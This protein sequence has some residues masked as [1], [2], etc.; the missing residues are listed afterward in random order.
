M[1]INGV[2]S[3]WTAA[4]RR[5]GWEHGLEAAAGLA[6]AVALVS[7]LTG[8]GVR[9]GSVALP[10][11]EAWRPAL[12]GLVILAGR[13]VLSRRR[14]HTAAAAR[15]A[16]SRFDGL[17]VLACSCGIAASVLLWSHY[18]IRF[19]GGSDSYGYV[20]AAHALAEGH[21]IE[22]QPIAGWLTFANPIRAITPLGSAP[23]PSGNAIVPGYP[24]GLSVV[25]ALFILVAGPGAEFYVPLV[26][27]IGALVLCY[28]LTSRWADWRVAAIATL[29]IAC[30]PLIANMVIQPMSD[31]PALFWYLLAL[32]IAL[33]APR[34]LTVAGL[35]MGLAIWTR[36]TMLFVLP[37]V[38]WI[39][40]RTRD[41]WMRF[42]AGLVPVGAAVAGFQ[43]YMYG[44]PLKTGYG[45]VPGLFRASMALQN[46]PAY[47][48][49]LA[50]I[51]SPLVFVAFAIGVWRGP[52]RLLVA[53]LAGFA[54]GFLPY[55]FKAPFF[56]DYGLLRYV[57]QVLV[58][59]L[60]V[61][62][63]G[64]AELCRR[65]LSPRLATVALV[66]MTMA[67]ASYSY[68]VADR[69]G[70][71]QSVNQESRYGAVGDWVRVHTPPPSVVLADVHSGSLRFYAHRTTLYFENLPD[72]A[73][74]T[75]VRDLA[76][77]G[78]VCFAALDGEDEE[79]R[80]RQRF[81]GEFDR[82]AIDPIGLIRGTT[83]YR[84]QPKA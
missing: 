51:H 12:L 3:R 22:P 57:M 71:F 56:D 60:L 69:E 45:T 30:N 42:A 62:V 76:Q 28:R 44:S 36:P 27:G 7:A 77:R 67:L 38:C 31:V 48:K 53:A 26:A 4:W 65:H 32:D 37:V 11:R 18:Q 61:A 83:V 64:V 47:A 49:W 63:I 1:T 73:L 20:S 34:L 84:L 79:R 17:V 15:P 55:V 6:F 2:T 9:I 5:V 54:L 8:S 82:V 13:A 16:V 41:A 29:V 10:V 35:A 19:C 66:G 14:A 46:L 43:W 58:P 50:I 23:A 24:L 75:T 74:A 25:M 21:L 52:R 59:C 33:H 72:T 70:T 81:A 80:F 68:R 78:I 39:M 40:P